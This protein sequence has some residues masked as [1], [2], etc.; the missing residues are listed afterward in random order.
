M[1]DALHHIFT[2]WLSLNPAK[3]PSEV[4]I[5]NLVYAVVL[6]RSLLELVSSLKRRILTMPETASYGLFP[7]HCG[8]TSV[9]RAN[10]KFGPIMPDET[11]WPMTLHIED[12]D[13]RLVRSR[14]R[15]APRGDGGF[16]VYAEAVSPDATKM[17]CLFTTQRGTLGDVWTSVSSARFDAYPS[18]L[19]N[20]WRHHGELAGLLTVSDPLVMIYTQVLIRT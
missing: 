7:S 19:D 20:D 3:A 13:N 11:E 9:Y 6:F 12:H 10:I 14:P 5:Y 17:S 2:A 4:Q 18:G 8:E 15:T 16:N 1:D